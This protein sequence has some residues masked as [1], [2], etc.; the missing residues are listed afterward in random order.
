MR[1]ETKT[2][3]PPDARLEIKA[4]EG[5]AVVISGLASVF[6]G[7]DA[8][9]DTI[10]PGSYQK[11]IGA[12]SARAW[13]M[14]MLWNHEPSDLIGRWVDFREDERGLVATGELTPNHSKAADA[15]ASLRHGALTGLSIGYRATAA[16]IEKDGRR[17]L[18]EIDLFEVSLVT[19]PADL[20]AR[21]TGVKSAADFTLR[22]LETLIREHC[23]FS[24]RE[25]EAALRGALK[26]F[27]NA[28]DERDRDDHSATSER[29]DVGIE[30]SPLL[31][32][33]RE[34]RLTHI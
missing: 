2:V 22:D 6:H 20:S 11:T 4:V 33:L 10:L 5:E 3:A 28:R 9:N 31:A 29:R 17:V 18:R 12:W 23:G 32:A 13:P 19:M 16:D 34:L 8:Y 14:P 24:R 25:T 30:A 26:S 1:V 21:V 15:V 27:A 7:L